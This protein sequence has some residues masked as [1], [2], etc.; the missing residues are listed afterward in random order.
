MEDEVYFKRANFFPGL[1]ATPGFWNEI[2]DY[3][4]NKESLYNNLFHGFG[5]VPEYKQ[6][7]HVQA[8]KTKGG[9]ITLLI[10]TG[11]SSKTHFKSFCGAFFKKRPSEI[12]LRRTR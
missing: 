11:I 2:E 6:S 10:G 7:L 12:R 1:K 3:H 8:E 9:L 4:F 5:I